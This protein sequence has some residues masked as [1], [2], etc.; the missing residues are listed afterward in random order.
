MVS[1]KS[2]LKYIVCV[3]AV[4]LAATVDVFAETVTQKEAL[5]IATQFFNE[6]NGNV[7]AVPKLVFNGRKLT[8]GR[9]FTPFYVYNHPMGGFVIVSAENKAFPILGF[10]RTDSF[11]PNNIDGN[12][13]ALLTLYAMHIEKIRY[14]SS[15]VNEAVKAWTD[16]PGYIYALLHDPYEA[17]DI[18]VGKDEAEEL[19]YAALDGEKGSDLYSDIYS[20]GQWNDMINSQLTAERNV[21]LGLLVGESAFPVIVQGRRGDMYRISFPGIHRALFRLFPTEILTAGEVA[22]LSNPIGAPAEQETDEAFRFH[23]DFVKEVN[24]GNLAARM[25]IE[26][27]LIPQEPVVRP[28]G[29][30]FFTIDMP[31]PP[32]SARVYNAAGA[33]VKVHTYRNTPSAFI[34][35]LSAPRGF[36]VAIIFT[37]NGNSYGLK[38]YK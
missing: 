11:D 7:M 29:S 2:S 21:V 20:A 28:N 35:I 12:L 6:S 4:V 38:L 8:T 19:L 31:D 26:N 15:L 34:D 3:V 37:E 18:L 30:G 36:Y 14:D 24:A 1:M 13:K 25:K 5:R 23:D 16:I 17:T 33:L 27:S 10:S 22:V 32:V 9:L